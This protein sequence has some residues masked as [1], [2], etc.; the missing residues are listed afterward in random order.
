MVCHEKFGPGKKL[1][2]GSSFFHEKSGPPLPKVIR[3]YQRYPPD[4]SK[5]KKRAIGEKAAMFNVRKGVLFI[6][7]KKKSVVRP[8]FS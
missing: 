1:D 3:A 4:C 7:K 8:D 5:D 2:R 6:K